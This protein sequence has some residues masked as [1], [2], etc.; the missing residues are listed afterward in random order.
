MK[1]AI[2]V[3]PA[4]APSE[5]HCIDTLLLDYDQRQRPE[6]S[7]AALRGTHIEMALTQPVRLRTDDR[8][9]LDDDTL[10]EI[11]ARPEPLYEL[12]ATNPSDLARIAWMLGDRHLPVDI[13]ERR[14]RVRRDPVIDTLLGNAAVKIVAI[15]APFEP[16]GGA[17]SHVTSDDAAHAHQMCA[18]SEHDHHDH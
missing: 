3:L 9:V 12:R 5:L 17:Y 2:A 8:L 13:S 6:G 11:V 1:R 18:H 16:E 10:I 7:H 4:G 14:L 15:D